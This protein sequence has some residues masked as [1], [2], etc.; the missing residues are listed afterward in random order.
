M[1]R[2]TSAVA[3]IADPDEVAKITKTYVQLIAKY[4]KD[5]HEPCIPLHAIVAHPANT[6]GDDIKQLCTKCLTATLANGGVDHVEG[7]QY[8]RVCEGWAKR[9]ARFSEI[10]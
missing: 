6:G 8:R 4:K 3:E 9:W 2:G 1:S 5:E 7:K 10:I